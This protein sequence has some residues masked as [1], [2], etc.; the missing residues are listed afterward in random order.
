VELE[1]SLVALFYAYQSIYPNDYSMKNRFCMALKQAREEGI[2]S[3]AIDKRIFRKVEPKYG[4]EHTY[5]A[6]FILSLSKSYS[7][8][9]SYDF[10]KEYCEK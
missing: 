8:P 6:E 2:L 9:K 7:L 3:V 1:V 4:K 10:F 5:A